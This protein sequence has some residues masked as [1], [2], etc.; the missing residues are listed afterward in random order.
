MPKTSS[1]YQP[2][3]L[4]QGNPENSVELLS[5]VS[6]LLA[7]PRSAPTLHLIQV[8]LCLPGLCS[9]RYMAIEWWIFKTVEITSH[10]GKFLYQGHL[11]LPR[12]SFIL[13]AILSL[14]T[15]ISS[16]PKEM[17]D[18]GS[19]AA[20]HF[21]FA[22]CWALLVCHFL[23]PGAFLTWA[24]ATILAIFPATKSVV[25]DGVSKSWNIFICHQF[26]EA[27]R[28]KIQFLRVTVFLFL[29]WPAS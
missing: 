4:A 3:F 7:L 29:S 20:R 5:S 10:A 24:V 17:V 14:Y 23:R 25:S 6:Q 22:S 16:R 1:T 21:L 8:F 11:F 28:V 2:I 13:I 18:L 12:G 19:N 9:R 27:L 15:I 26:P